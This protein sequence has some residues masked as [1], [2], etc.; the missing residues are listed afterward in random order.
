MHDTPRHTHPHLQHL[1]AVFQFVQAEALL[2]IA[3][4][5]VCVYRR[6]LLPLVRVGASNTRVS[7]RTVA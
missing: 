4:D 6:Q 3:F 7:T 1:V 5:F 2:S